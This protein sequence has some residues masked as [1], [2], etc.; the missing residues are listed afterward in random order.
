MVRR[1]N[2]SPNSFL[3]AWKLVDIFFIPI[4]N[5]SANAVTSLATWQSYNVRQE[6][7]NWNQNWFSMH[8]IDKQF[9]NP[10]GTQV[11]PNWIPLCLIE[12]NCS[13]QKNPLDY[14]F[15]TP[16]GH[17]SLVS[18]SKGNCVVFEEGSDIL[19]TS[20]SN[21]QSRKLIRARGFFLVYSF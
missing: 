9:V 16:T 15:R 12:I 4:G 5:Q 3:D 19:R 1:E 20:T 11:N 17:N 2:I 13:V 21:Y 14:N 18:T 7:V 8:P 6:K 10:I